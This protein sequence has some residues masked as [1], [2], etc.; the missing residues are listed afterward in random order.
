VCVDVIRLQRN[1]S[2]AGVFG[3]LYSSVVLQD[4]SKRVMRFG[5]FGPDRHCGAQ[6][7]F[8]PAKLAK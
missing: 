3:F 4:G 2:A 6:T 5:K 7:R 8:G 1:C